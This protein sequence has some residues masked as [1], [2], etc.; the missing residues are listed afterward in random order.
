[1]SKID[2]MKIGLG[3]VTHVEPILKTIVK[4]RGEQKHG[5]PE[6]LKLQ[7]NF[8]AVYREYFENES[9]AEAFSEFCTLVYAMKKDQLPPIHVLV[10]LFK[11]LLP[12]M[13]PKELQGE[14]SHAKP[15]IKKVENDSKFKYGV[16]LGEVFTNENDAK[17]HIIESQYIQSLRL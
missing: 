5:K 11:A 15:E 14:Q 13:Q 2:M 4:I 3:L 7:N 12:I 17:S 16:I 8:V 6:L 1:M 9:D 10:V